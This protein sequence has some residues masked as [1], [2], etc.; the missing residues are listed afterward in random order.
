M[1]GID[2]SN[3]A[4]HREPGILRL[5]SIDRGAKHVP[6]ER[7]STKSRIA[8][9]P[10][11]A[12]G[13]DARADRHRRPFQLSVR[14]PDGSPVGVQQVQR[15]QVV[16]LRFVDLEVAPDKTCPRAQESRLAV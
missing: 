4:F 7:L 9:I 6:H 14:L 12:A 13:E 5:Q 15:Y 16:E 10:G 1:R 8:E 3:L 11:A 2:R